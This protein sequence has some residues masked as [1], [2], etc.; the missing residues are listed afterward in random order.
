MPFKGNLSQLLNYSL[1]KIFSLSLNPL[2]L[3]YPIMSTHWS[4]PFFET[5]DKHVKEYINTY[6]DPAARTQV[7]RNC[8]KDILDSPLLGDKNP[9]IELPQ[10]LCLV[11]VSFH[12]ITCAY[13]VA[14]TN[15]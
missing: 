1:P 2:P 13:T 5:L 6:K 14:I 4:I 7:L 8:R 9:N 3:F 12:Y 10:H 11:R 15:N